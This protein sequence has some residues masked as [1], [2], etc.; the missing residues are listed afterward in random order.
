MESQVTD[1]LPSWVPEWLALDIAN[2]GL[3][4]ALDLTYYLTVEYTTPS[5]YKELRGICD[6][7]GGD[8]VMARRI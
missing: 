2:L 5:Y 4:A 3:G 8:Y 6:A 1:A 7:S